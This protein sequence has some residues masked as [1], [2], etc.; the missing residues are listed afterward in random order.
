MRHR[1]PMCTC[2][3]PGV[4][5]A[6]S[7][8]IA[9][10]TCVAPALAQ[11]AAQGGDTAKALKELTAEIRILRATIERTS[12]SQLQGQVLGLYL[13]LQQ[14]RVTQATARLDSVR[15]EVE[16]V[17]NQSRATADQVAEMDAALLQE[18][19]PVKRRAFEQ[20]Q[21]DFKQQAAQIAAMEQQVRQRETEA[22]QAAQTEEQ[23]WTELIGRLEQLLKK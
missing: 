15:R 9:L 4:R 18:T 8:V 7:V 23:R 22:E 12:E 2:I 3:T 16:G 6:A 14:N 20:Q 5:T 17:T 13:S 11:E 21:R 19:D 10:L 1:R